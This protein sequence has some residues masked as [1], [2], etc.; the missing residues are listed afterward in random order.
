MLY[1]D[2]DLRLKAQWIR[3]ADVVLIGPAMI[4]GGVLSWRSGHPL[5]GGLLAT[6]GVLTIAFNAYNFLALGAED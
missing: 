6:L 2:R 3:L 4:G 5:L 1:Y